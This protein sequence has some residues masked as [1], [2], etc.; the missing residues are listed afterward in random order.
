MERR[1][2]EVPM[3]NPR[4][5][6]GKQKKIVPDI[7]SKVGQWNKRF[8]DGLLSFD[9]YDP[10]TGD[11]NYDEYGA[12]ADGL[13]SAIKE[14][15]EAQSKDFFEEGSFEFDTDKIFSPEFEEME[16]AQ[17][18]ECLE[19]VLAHLHFRMFKRKLTN[20]ETDPGW[21]IQT[22]EKSILLGD[23]GADYAKRGAYFKQV[24]PFFLHRGGVRQF[25]DRR[26]S[27]AV[28]D[29]LGSTR[30]D[31]DGAV[32]FLTELWIKKKSTGD[33]VVFVDRI[34]DAVSKLNPNIAASKLLEHMSRGAE[35]KETISAALCRLEFGK[36]NISE[37]GV[38]YLERLY[39]LG[40]YNNPDFFVQRLT[41]N[42]Q[43]GIFDDDR[44]LQKFFDLGDLSSDEREV[45]ATVLDFTLEQFFSQPA[46]EGSEERQY[47]EDILEDF[48]N[49]YFKFYD[50][51]FFKKS[52]VQFNNLSF[53]EQAWF[54]RFAL[55]AGAEEQDKAFALVREYGENGL[56]TFISLELDADS[57]DKI[58]AVAEKYEGVGAKEIFRKYA[59]IAA[60]AEK[61]EIE[62]S[63]FF[64]ESGRAEEVSGQRVTQ[65][66][67]KRAARVIANFAE[68]EADEATLAEIDE[69]LE[70]IDAELVMFGS[71][72][73]AVFKGKEDVDFKEVR[74]LD[75][76][77]IDIAELSDEEKEEMLNVSKANWL[78]R[79]A[80]G[81]GVVEEFERTLEVGK[82][83]DFSVLKKDGKILSFMR[84]DT[85]RDEQGRI[86]PDRKYA[87]SFNVDP[88]YRGSAVGEAMLINALEREAQ[89][90]VLE[91]TVS[92]KI[93][94]GTD[95]VEKRGFSITNVLPNYDNSGETFFEIILDKKGNKAFASKGEEFSHDKIISMYDTIYKD[96]PIDELVER[97]MV[98]QRF[99][100][101]E[102]SNDILTTTE[103]LVNE[104]YVGTR[105]FSDSKDKRRRYYVF[106]KDRRKGVIANAA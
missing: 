24:A 96:R 12:G 105:Y 46:P 106:E 50:N 80:A 73:K 87:G 97:D 70:K 1:L 5:V 35:D 65:E 22:R 21:A 57:S 71:I 77:R 8:R 79:G 31:V 45:K 60:A 10:G 26:L 32:D 58:F 37:D 6:K 78:P 30:E 3:S 9:Y 29:K 23:Q 14:V 56:K 59:E 2:K 72:F 76:L 93:V 94:V 20:R 68:R 67:M 101:E 53:R 48:K 104:G 99:D 103:R 86:V 16:D 40:E 61:V 100:T 7:E 98:I 82:D 44:V 54:M 95:Y 69:E 36:L 64:V 13:L 17:K 38:R 15:D 90:Y 28:I 39:D 55:K 92:P 62:V 49:N 11:Q 89:D 83:I 81:R 42:G 47:Q 43:I 19:T 102:Q 18:V 52:R 85:I 84:F 63:N 34:T 25:L 88:R 74:G 27:L 75:F 66:I 4:E 51:D 41:A 91:A 33:R